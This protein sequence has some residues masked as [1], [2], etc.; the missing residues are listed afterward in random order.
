MKELKR[1]MIMQAGAPEA[2]AESAAAMADK[3]ELSSDR[4]RVST[5][6][7][8]CL[9]KFRW[10]DDDE[11]E[12]PKAVIPA[13]HDTVEAGRS[14]PAR[15]ARPHRE[16]APCHPPEAAIDT[17]RVQ[18]GYLDKD[19][20][21]DISAADGLKRERVRL[22]DIEQGWQIQH[23]ELVHAKLDEPD[24][25]NWGFPG[26]GT[27]VL[28][29]LLA[30]G[31]NGK[32]IMGFLPDHLDVK[33]FSQ[34][35]VDGGVLRYNTGEAICA[36]LASKYLRDGDILLI[37]A[38]Y[39][40]EVSGMLLPVETDPLA[41]CAIE[42]AVSKG[43]VVIEAAGNGSMHLDNLSLDEDPSTPPLFDPEHPSGAI[44][45]AAASAEAPHTR[46]FFTNRGK[47]VQC[48]AWGEEVTTCGD[49]ETSNDASDYLPDFGGTSAAAAIV[50]GVAALVQS[51]ARGMG[52][53]LTGEQLRALLVDPALGT[54]TAPGAA[55]IGVM[56]NVGKII[57]TLR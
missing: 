16:M 13:V 15:L 54:L 30:K 48:F 52:K 39:R 22:I 14:L 7:C 43:I 35:W 29:I 38:Q 5:D 40:D 10:S 8:D 20:G 12:T 34:Y 56:P 11:G 36:A 41:R 1:R 31:T 19:L 26:H 28:G 24:G 17:Y 4:W 49:G 21:V 2:H 46:M 44:L 6:A 23:E 45:V 42:C 25:G 33:L 50:A 51:V 57:D 27:S 55:P 3:P 47:A 9:K 53:P 18:Q 32:G 37:E